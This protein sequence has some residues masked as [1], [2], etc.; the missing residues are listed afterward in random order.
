M[1]FDL[2]DVFWFSLEHNNQSNQVQMRDKIL[3]M[4]SFQNCKNMAK[5]DND[6]GM[7]VVHFNKEVE[8]RENER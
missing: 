1:A 8:V 3:M 4:S 2:S 6:S 5:K 7:V